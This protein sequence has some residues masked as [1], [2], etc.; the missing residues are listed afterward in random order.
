MNNY[1][2][3]EFLIVTGLSGA[4]KTKAVNALED[5]GF[6]CVDNLPPQLLFTFTKLIMDSK[7]KR[8]KIAVVLD[9]RLGSSFKD[10]IGVIENLKHEHI[11]YQIL[12]ID[13]DTEILER[14]FQETR[15]KHPLA[16]SFNTSNI[17]AAIEAERKIML[18]LREKAD[19]VIDTSNVMSSQ[20][21]ERIINLFMNNVESSLKIY[22]TSFG[23][24]YGIP[25]ES[26]LVFDVRCLP[27][28]FYIPELKHQTGLDKGVKDFVMNFSQATELKNKLF[29]LID[30]LIPLYITEG[31]SQLTISIGC[32]GGRHRS[33]LF[34]ELIN[35]HLIE[36]GHACS[37]F[38][39]DIRK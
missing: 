27:N 22:A 23:F 18:P 31:K 13:A 21:K 9:I 1:D 30:F 32:T 7:E 26:D 38:H 35:K 28:P 36:N 34:S 14:R 33:V 3:Q 37:V 15:R 25:N 29:D 5:I 2:K 6:F 12:F 24:K 16:E 11:N 8:G 10:V 39:R 17:T 4:G 20:F 19:F